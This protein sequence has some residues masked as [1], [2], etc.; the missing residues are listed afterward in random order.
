MSISKRLIKLNLGLHTYLCNF[1]PN[2]VFY[3]WNGSYMMTTLWI[4]IS[5]FY[6]L[7]FFILQTL[8]L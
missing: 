3:A 6:A 4:K 5:T 1:L 7:F 8:K 2:S